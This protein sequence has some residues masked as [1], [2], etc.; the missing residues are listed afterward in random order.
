MIYECES[1]HYYHVEAIFLAGPHRQ[2]IAGDDIGWHKLSRDHRRHLGAWL[3]LVAGMRVMRQTVYTTA[4]G[5][6]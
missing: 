5:P 1:M 2:I 4:T 3:M 6:M